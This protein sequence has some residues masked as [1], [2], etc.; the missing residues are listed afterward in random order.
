MS[1]LI[2]LVKTKTMSG[3]VGFGQLYMANTKDEEGAVKIVQET[4][5]TLDEEVLVVHSIAQQVLDFFDVPPG[6]AK[7]LPTD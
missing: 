2:V 3:Q 6:K 7:L 5:Q 1:G 4:A